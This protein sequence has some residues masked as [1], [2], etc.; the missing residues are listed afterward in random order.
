MSK[1]WT[2]LHGC[3][4]PAKSPPRR[5][6]PI[7]PISLNMYAGLSVGSSAFSCDFAKDTTSNCLSGE[8]HAMRSAQMRGHS[9]VARG[10]VR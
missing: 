9:R 8:P 6:N 10:E 5:I 2:R 4:S 1:M 3:D 7:D